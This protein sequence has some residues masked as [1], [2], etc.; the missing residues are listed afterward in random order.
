MLINTNLISKRTV[1]EFT[2]LIFFLKGENVSDALRLHH[3]SQ[4]QSC[5]LYYSTTASMFQGSEILIMPL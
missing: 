5:L 2:K 4:L 3:Q 1:R